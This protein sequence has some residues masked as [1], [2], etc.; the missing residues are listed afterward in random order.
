MPELFYRLPRNVIVI[1]SGR[2]FLWHA[3]AILLTIVI[4]MSGFDWTYFRWTRDDAF[5][6]LAR[7]AIIIGT[8]LPLAAILILLLVG[9]ITKNCRLVTTAWALGQAALLGYLISCAFKAFTGRLPPP[10]R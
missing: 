3:F 9:T 1:F 5:V 10:F 6:R 4:V 8:F 2:N 7:P